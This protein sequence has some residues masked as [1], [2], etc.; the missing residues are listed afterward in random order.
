MRVLVIAPHP[1]DEVLGVGGTIARCVR[2]GDHVSVVIVTCGSPPLFDEG[3]VQRV[4]LEAVA[5]H[6]VLG[7]SDTILLTG[8]PAAK[9]DTIPGHELNAALTDVVRTVRPDM[10]FIPFAGDIHRDHQMVF[11]AS[12]VATRPR[13]G[14]TVRA[15]YA[16]ETVSETN[17]Y[18]PPLTP[19]FLPNTFIAIDD[20]LDVKLNALKEYSSQVKP[21]PDERS[22]EAVTAL[23]RVRGATVGF[24]AA[25]GFVLIRQSL[26]GSS[27]F[28]EP[29]TVDGAL[30]GAVRG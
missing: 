17:W 25:E 4:R 14:C 15:I 13:D 6:R 21:F 24:K 8:F 27:S 7:V 22:L 28:A 12:L 10:V 23:A 2:S 11:T 3:D 26:G 5:A 30:A 18:A 9:L 19:G 1:D 29:W 20:Y 16:Y